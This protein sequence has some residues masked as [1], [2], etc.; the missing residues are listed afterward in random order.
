M[1]QPDQTRDSATVLSCSHLNGITIV[2]AALAR[3]WLLAMALTCHQAVKITA[4]LRSS[5][6][7]SLATRFG[8]SASPGLSS[9]A[10]GTRT[11]CIIANP[12]A[13]MSRVQSV[14]SKTTTA[15][16]LAATSPQQRAVHI[17][18]KCALKQDPLWPY[19]RILLKGLKFHGYHGVFNAEKELGQKFVVDLELH[20]CLAKAGWFCV[21]CPVMHSGV[22]FT[23]ISA[24]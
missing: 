24:L 13:N 12:Q 11:L 6:F 16:S 3:Y 1:W 10:L 18:S 7:P 20:V 23:H 17:V 15:H 19:D 21:R 14:A 8:L 22:A 2:L 5:T 9:A 4:A